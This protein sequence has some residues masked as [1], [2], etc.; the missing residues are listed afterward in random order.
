MKEY[1]FGYGYNLN[2]TNFCHRLGRMMKSKF[3]ILPDYELVFNVRSE[4]NNKSFANIQPKQGEIVMGALYQL[5]KDELEKLDC[6]EDVKKGTYQRIK[7]KVLENG[8]KQVY[9]WTY[10]CLD[11]KWQNENLLPEEKYV[12]NIVSSLLQY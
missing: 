3:A 12:E 10:I 9:A 5:N 8:E 1:Y 6:F 4:K 11:P 7:V 2:E